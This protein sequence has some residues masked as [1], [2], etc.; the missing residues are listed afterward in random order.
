MKKTLALLGAL[1][2]A[3][4]VDVETDP[5]ET[6]VSTAAVVEFDPGK[7]IIP[8]PNNLLLDRTTGKVTL[9]A[10]C[11]ESAT[12]KLLRELVV[13]AL[14]GFGTF[15]TAM[16]ITFTQEV[17]ATSLTADTVVMYRRATGTTPVMPGEA[18]KVPLVFIPGTTTRFDADCANPTQIPSVTVVPAIPLTERSTY[19]VAVLSGVKAKDGSS[20]GASSTWGLVRLKDNPVTV[21][22]GVVVSD[23]TPLNPGDAEDRATLL[24]LNLLWNAHVQ[25]LGFIEAAT[26]KP[27]AD[28]LLSW[29]FNTQTTTRPL[30][31]TVT[32]TPA[33]A[34]PK[35]ALIS[36]IS[37]LLPSEATV[38]DHM[39]A[40]LRANFGAPA[41]VCTALGCSSVGLALT[42]TL[43]A[44]NY[45]TPGTNPLA[46]GTPV[47][48]PWTSPVTPTKISDANI[49]VRILTPAGARPA[50]GWPT[51]FFGHGLGGNRFMSYLIGSALARTG[52][53]TVSIDFVAHGARAVRISDQGAC[54]TPNP[55]LTP[56]CYAPIFSTNL[57][58]TRDNI[59]QTVLDLQTLIH[60]IKACTPAVPCG[61]GGVSFA[62]DPTKMGYM[63]ISLGGIVGSV[64]AATASDLKASVLNVAAVGLVDVLENTNN[65]TIRCSTVDGLIDAGIIVGGTKWNGMTGAGATGTCVGTEWRTQPGYLTFSSIARWIL[66]SSDGANF[67]GRLA[68]RRFLLQKVVGDQVVPNVATESLA[69]LTGMT[70]WSAGDTAAAN[71]LPPS[72]II[73]T[74]P[75]ANKWVEYTSN[76]NFEFSHGSLLSGTTVPQQFAT[77]RIQTDAI[78]Y[79]VN[80]I[81]VP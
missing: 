36:L 30:D 9:P 45:Q 53:A 54:A 77:G 81:L 3:S 41:G 4:C 72:A 47:P 28:I 20:F 80:N 14:D 43:S 11:G 75:K 5:S 34:L 67:A 62:A 32:G 18:I 39:E 27:R 42:G 56:Q 70:A 15:K 40:A 65:L 38:S 61:S 37:G 48:G 29:E 74:N 58:A 73:T 33:N 25:A 17:D 78:V 2:A 26:A 63:G 21:E 55:G 50:D 69:R 13:N 7:S 68:L 31:P 16:R 60:A 6:A 46:G 64:V 51:I 10:Q 76:A 49:N 59:R 35:T 44:P 71:P 66:D 22:N 23:R 12:A 8:F 52:F 79:L 57:A 19:T 24:G 1:A